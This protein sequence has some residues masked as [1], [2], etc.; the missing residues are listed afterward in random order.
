MNCKYC[1]KLFTRKDNLK[2]HQLFSCSQRPSASDDD[3][4]DKKME[5]DDKS[6]REEEL[7][8]DGDSKIDCFGNISDY[9]SVQSEEEEEQENNKMSK[10]ESETWEGIL[11]DADLQSSIEVKENVSELWNDDTKLIKVVRCL[12][13]EIHRLES[14][15]KKLKC[16]IIY[17]DI[18]EDKMKMLK[19]GYS[20][21]E[22]T[23]LAWEKRKYLIGKL[24]SRNRKLLE[25]LYFNEEEEDDEEDE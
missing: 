9:H 16:G 5:E 24:L 10:N 25:S 14:T 11:K 15:L 22:A 6:S 12:A 19:K 17:P 2:R 7:D 18:Y 20:N 1:D 3:D 23:L 21:V 13:F 4:D 8:T